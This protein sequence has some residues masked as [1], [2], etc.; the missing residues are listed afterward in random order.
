MLVDMVRVRRENIR[1]QILLTLD[2][3]RPLGAYEELVLS[4]IQ[5]TYPDTTLNEVR[6]E[7]DYLRD[8]ELVKI[9]HRPDGRWFADLMR[10]GIDVVEYTV[11]CDAGIAR[12]PKYW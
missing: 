5:A 12:P 6:R 2:K 10:Y 3:A 11:E 1:W 9:D 4:V 8:R 7:M